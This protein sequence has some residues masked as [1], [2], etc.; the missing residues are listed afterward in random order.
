MAPWIPY[1]GLVTAM[2]LWSTSFIALKLAFTAYDPLVVIFGRMFIATLCFLPFL[3]RLLRGVVYRKGDWRLLLLMTLCEP[4]F[5]FVFEAKALVLTTASQAGMI[6]SMLPLLVTF[7][8]VAGLGEQVGRKTICGFALAICGAVGL[9]LAGHA[10]PDAP[11][12]VLGNFYEF[13]AMICAAGYTLLLKYLSD[14]YP[15]FLLTA[16][17]AICGS[18][19]FFPALFF[20]HTNVPSALVPVPAVA[21]LYLGTCITLG[22]YGLYNFGV[23]KIPASQASAFINLIPVFTVFFGWLI[24]HETF[25]SL[26]YACS[27]LV[28]FGV[29]VSQEDPVAED[30]RQKEVCG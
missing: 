9:S 16:F 6:S 18:V 8:A 25:T 2:V 4:C 28:L 5:Y 26:Q 22:A 17:Q 14:R 12:P 27:G 20:P 30:T 23:S 7:G 24:L 21:I 19:F 3:P 1:T 13:L 15:P 29:Y 10:S 11:N